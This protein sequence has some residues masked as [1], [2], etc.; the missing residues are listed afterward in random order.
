M[1]TLTQTVTARKAKDDGL[2]AESLAIVSREMTGEELRNL[3]K[4]LKL[5][6]GEFAARLG[7]SRITIIRSEMGNPSREIQA[8]IYRAF[9][10]G[11]LPLPGQMGEGVESSLVKEEPPKR[12][13]KRRGPSP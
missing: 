8:L 1:K 2:K 5:T 7:I 4:L 3:R 13:Y 6:Q 11:A 9:K 10:T 12:P